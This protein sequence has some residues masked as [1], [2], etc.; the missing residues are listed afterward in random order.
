MQDTMYPVVVLVSG[1]ASFHLSNC[2]GQKQEEEELKLCA[3][4]QNTKLGK[5]GKKRKGKT[6]CRSYLSLAL[7]ASLMSYSEF[8]TSCLTTA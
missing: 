5:E 6:I 8:W 3:I 7:H 2:H 1:I 4:I